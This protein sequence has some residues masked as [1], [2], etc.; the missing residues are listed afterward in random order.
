MQLGMTVKDCKEC[1]G[2]GHVK[3]ETIEIPQNITHITDTVRISDADRTVTV[4]EVLEVKHKE[5]PKN[6]KGSS[7]HGKERKGK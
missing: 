4:H 6:H 2:I 3:A 7:S 5:E 1:G